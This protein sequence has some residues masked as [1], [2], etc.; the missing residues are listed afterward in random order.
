MI[1][2]AGDGNESRTMAEAEKIERFLAS[3]TARWLFRAMTAKPKARPGG[4]P[5]GSCW[6]QRFFEAYADGSVRWYQPQFT[7]PY[8]LTEYVR[9]KSGAVPNY[10]GPPEGVRGNPYYPGGIY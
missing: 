5:G 8:L 6:L 10:F 1:H 2:L 7:L 9:R 3:P 4:K